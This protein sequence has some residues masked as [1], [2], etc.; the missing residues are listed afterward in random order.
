MFSAQV[1]NIGSMKRYFYTF[2]FQDCLVFYLIWL[3]LKGSF[4]L[5]DLLNP[6]FEK[7]GKE[8]SYQISKNNQIIK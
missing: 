8:N 3:F 7:S 4:V 6:A 2:P 1:K 5:S